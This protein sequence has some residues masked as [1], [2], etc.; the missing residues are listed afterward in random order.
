[1]N[2]KQILFIHGGDTY[3][4]YEDYLDFI[5]NIEISEDEARGIKNG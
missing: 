2:K 5:K 1:M 3:E 4:S